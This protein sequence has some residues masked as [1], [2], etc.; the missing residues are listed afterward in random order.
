M[1]PLGRLPCATHPKPDELLSSWFTRLAHAHLAKSYTFG[2]LL[3]PTISFLNR[4]LDKIAPEAVLQTLA[5][6]TST[7]LL[8]IRET[9]LRRYEGRLYLR[10][11]ANGNT[12]WLLPLGIYHRTHRRYGLLFCPTCLHNDG[13]TPYFRTHWRLALSQVCTR[14][15]VYLQ[16][17]CPA[18]E[19]PVTF[20]RV[21]VGRKSALPDTPIS[22]CFYCALDLASIPR[23]KASSPDMKR[24]LEL[25]RILREGWEEGVFYPHLYFDVL[26]QII[27]LLASPNPRC[28]ALQ[29]A[30]DKHTG[31]SPVDEAIPVRA[32]RTAFE[33]LPLQTRSGLLRQAYWLLQEWP[34]RFL[35][36]TR[37][38]HV[39]STPLLHSMSEIPFWYHDV[40]QTH[41]H[42]SNRNRRFGD[43]WA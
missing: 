5:D 6:R 31:W 15:G 32:G 19:R 20:F 12:N 4:D 26:H 27:K 11:N 25:E 39:T 8:R 35:D 10:H 7:P 1:S 38:N 42:M 30:V 16:E 37:Q 41:L 28:A 34:T 14:C 2:K 3:L 36:I 24:Q 13:N 17:K 22:H 40:V 43:F 29:V 9:A 23:E 33:L 21:E 18:C